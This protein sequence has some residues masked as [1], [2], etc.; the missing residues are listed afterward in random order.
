MKPSVPFVIERDEFLRFA[1]TEGILSVDGADLRI[2]FR[3]ADTVLGLLK[4]RLHEVRIPLDAIEE[5]GLR[6]AWPWQFFLFI[7][8]AEMGKASD[9]PNFKMGEI[10]LSIPK[11]H[12]QAAAEL[13]SAVRRAAAENDGGP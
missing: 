5:I 6:K 12:S 7:R 9:L 2:E 8:V 10:V 11:R 4:S 1:V 3:T 13:A